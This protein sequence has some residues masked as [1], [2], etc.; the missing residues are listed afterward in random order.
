MLAKRLL[1]AAFFT[2]PLA[3]CDSEQE[4]GYEE[5]GVYEADQGVTGTSA[6]GD[7]EIP[8]EDLNDEQASWNEQERPS[9]DLIDEQAR[10]GGE[11]PSGDLIDEQ[12]KWNDQERPSEDLI[13]EQASVDNERP[14]EN[15]I[16]EQA[17][18]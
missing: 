7:S 17:S 9:E 3:A 18:I 14:S 11:R 2:L 5:G 8:S 4:V 15:L 6:Y 1:L 16:D 10:L 12:A 13:D